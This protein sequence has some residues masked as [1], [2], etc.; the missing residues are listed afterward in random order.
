VQFAKLALAHDVFFMR[1]LRLAKRI[2]VFGIQAINF[3]LILDLDLNLTRAQQT[4]R[5]RGAWFA[6]AA[7]FEREG[8]LD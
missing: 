3:G 5:A 4:S 1:G 2:A 7:S 6:C 8:R